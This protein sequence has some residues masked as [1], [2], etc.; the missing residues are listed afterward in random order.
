MK[1]MSIYRQNFQ[2]EKGSK[3]YRFPELQE[4][5]IRKGLYGKR[6]NIKWNSAIIL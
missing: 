1:K 2:P 5:Y 3:C 6:K 4:K